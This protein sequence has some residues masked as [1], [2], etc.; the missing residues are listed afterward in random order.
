MNIKLTKPI[1][2]VSGARTPFAKAFTTLRD[3]SAVQLGRCAVANALRR[4]GVTGDEIDELVMGN[5]AG[6]PDAANIARVIAL[7]ADIPQDRIAHTVNR[8]CA[9]GMESGRVARALA[10]NGFEQ[11]YSLKGGLP[12]WQNANLPL[13]KE[14]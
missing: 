2:V 6:P 10:A 5:V 7:K 1:A 8:N 14:T 13:T 12:S 9:S 11:V 4:A 3:L